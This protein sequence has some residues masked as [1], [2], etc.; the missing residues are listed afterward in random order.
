MQSLTSSQQ[1]AVGNAFELLKHIYT[2]HITRELLRA[3]L[4][5]S[6]PQLEK[7]A[8]GSG[9]WA[10]ETLV[11]L[12]EGGERLVQPPEVQ[13]LQGVLKTTHSINF[14]HS[15]RVTQEGQQAVCSLKCALY[16]EGAA[17]TN[18]LELVAFVSMTRATIMQQ[19]CMSVLKGLLSSSNCFTFFRLGKATGCKDLEE[20]AAAHAL[21]HF[22]SA[23]RKNKESF[24]ELDEGSLRQLLQH[25]HLQASASD[26]LRAVVYWTQHGPAF[27]I[28]LLKGTLGRLDMERVSS[29]LLEKL[30]ADPMV[31]QDPAVASLL[32]Q[33]L[34]QQQE[35]V[36]A[37]ALEQLHRPVKRLKLA[38]DSNN[39][40]GAT[41]AAT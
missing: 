27:R 16:G 24:K 6:D 10:S 38:A 41:A 31:Q 26:I 40:A 19:A 23:T 28:R 12:R 14:V 7:L 22:A 18:V 17:G 13:A 4:H 36:A 39:I 5:S 25:K 11:R 3:V 2:V 35:A 33:Q 21:K 34:Q 29:S 37:V 32:E 30:T 20:T 1:S 8:S 15:G 9:N